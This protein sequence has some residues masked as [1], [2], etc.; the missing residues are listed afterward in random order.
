MTGQSKPIVDTDDVPVETRSS[1]HEREAIKIVAEVCGVTP[2][3][4]AVALEAAE[5]DVSEAIELISMGQVIAPEGTTNKPKQDSI[6]D[7]ENSVM[8]CVGVDRETARAALFENDNDAMYACDALSN[9]WNPPRL[10]DTFTKL[11]STCCPTE[12]VDSLDK[13]K[14]YLHAV[15][16]ECDFRMVYLFLDKTQSI[17]VRVRFVR[18][19]M[20][21]TTSK[22]SIV[23]TN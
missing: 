16:T 6:I 20:F 12:T 5:F 22:V 11:N 8:E 10:D 17:D 14:I 3:I 1:E 15:R 23:I 7:K 4:A 18:L 13:V 19:F 9:G 21:I 2:K